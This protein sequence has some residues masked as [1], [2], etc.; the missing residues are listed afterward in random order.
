VGTFCSHAQFLIRPATSFLLCLAYFAFVRHVRTI[1]FRRPSWPA[2]PNGAGLF[3][4]CAGAFIAWPACASPYLAVGVGLP[5]RHS[6]VMLW[7]ISVEAKMPG[8]PRTGYRLRIDDTVIA[9]RLTTAQAEFLVAEILDRETPGAKMNGHRG[10][11]SPEHGHSDATLA[12]FDP[13]GAA[14]ARSKPRV[15]TRGS[16]GR[17]ALSAYSRRILRRA[18]RA[19]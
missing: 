5:E 19:P 18:E 13:L 3:C 9:D 4:A 6:D 10:P 17:Q 15:R 7:K 8:D 2:S 16:L 12:L 1:R 11:Q 14:R